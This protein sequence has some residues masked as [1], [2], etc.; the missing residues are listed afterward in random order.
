MNQLDRNLGTEPLVPLVKDEDFT[1]AYRAA[2]EEVRRHT[3][4]VSN[5]VRA[6]AHAEEIGIPTRKFL[7]QMWTLGDLEKP[8]RALIRYKVATANTCFYCSAHQIAY[9]QQFGMDREKIANIHD[10]ETH[11]AF[12]ERERAALAFVD[13]MTRDGANIPDRIARR[14]V[15]AFTPKERV[16][17][18][19]IAA[20]MGMLNKLNDAFRVPIEENAIEIAADVPEFAKLPVA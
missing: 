2:M 15:E 20:A 1:P 3:G 18:G 5:S 10:F 6:T 8:F 16:E 9:L 4:S 17:I 13:A 14:F 11:P 7:A 12:D 19:I